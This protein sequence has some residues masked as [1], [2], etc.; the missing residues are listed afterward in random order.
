[1]GMPG[2]TG[3]GLV[4]VGLQE[5]RVKLGLIRSSCAVPGVSPRRW[6]AVAGDQQTPVTG[7]SG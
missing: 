5:G 2:D 6:V 1:M 7:V 4:P 3:R